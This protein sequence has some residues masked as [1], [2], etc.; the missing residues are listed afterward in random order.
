M[1]YADLDSILLPEDNGKL[2]PN[3]CYTNKVVM[4]INYYLLTFFTFYN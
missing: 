3:K 1:I 2:N 4:V